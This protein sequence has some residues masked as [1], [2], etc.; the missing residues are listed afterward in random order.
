MA[1]MVRVVGL[2]AAIA[3]LPAARAGIEDCACDPG[4][5]A[6]MQARQ[7]SL[8]REALAHPAEAP[9]F[10]LKDA[11]PNK[12]HRLLAL[13]KAVRK[14]IHTLADMTPAERT[15]F[16]TTAIQKAKEL[17]GDAWGLAVNGEEM[18]TQCQPHIHIGKFLPAA[19]SRNFI[20]VDGPAQMPVPKDGGGLWVHPQG[21]K[22]HVH[23]GEQLTETV[24]LR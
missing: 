20:V 10:F 1:A 6:T 7:C 11:N 18:R 21:D 15:H 9:V 8:S 14:G 5:P 3:M 22:L 2:L 13:P 19:E 16:W 23:L 17:W 12:P 24:L 4:D